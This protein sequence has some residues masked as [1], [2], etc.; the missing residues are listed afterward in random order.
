MNNQLKFNPP[1]SEANPEISV[2]IPE[3]ED[4]GRIIT[5]L[6]AI[7]P[8]TNQPIRNYQKVFGTD[9]MNYFR[10]DSETGQVTLNQRV[11][12]E[13]I[14]NKELSFQ[15]RATSSGSPILTAVARVVVKVVDINDNSPKFQQN[16]SF[17]HCFSW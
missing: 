7:D 9:V 6:R 13:T 8:N 3:E 14:P 2:T 12:Y 15:V 5:T 11:D 1:W 17:I 4:I 16:V 10:V